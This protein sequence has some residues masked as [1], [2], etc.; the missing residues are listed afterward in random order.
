MNERQEIALVHHCRLAGETVHPRFARGH[1][2]HTSLLTVN[3]G[4]E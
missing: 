2:D 3:S 1:L 4:Y